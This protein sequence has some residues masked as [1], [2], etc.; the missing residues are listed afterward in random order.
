MHDVHFHLR[1]VSN[2]VLGPLAVKGDNSD[3]SDDEYFRSLSKALMLG[4]AYA[5]NIGG[6]GTLTGTPPNM[7][8]AGQLES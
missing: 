2:D 1:D 3:G 6:T 5:A 7:V 8:L 4:V